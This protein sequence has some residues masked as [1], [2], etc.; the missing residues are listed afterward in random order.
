MHTGR[1]GHG[2]RHHGHHGRPHGP[3]YGYYGWGGWPPGYGYP[4]AA[5]PY[6]YVG[7]PWWLDDGVISANAG[8]AMRHG[9]ELSNNPHAGA[10]GLR[11]QAQTRTLSGRTNLTTLDGEPL[12]SISGQLDSSNPF[13]F[14][15]DGRRLVPPYVPVGLDSRYRDITQALLGGVVVHLDRAGRVR[16]ANNILARG[17]CIYAANGAAYPLSK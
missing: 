4:W 12:F 14:T 8:G 17:A 6:E 3:P 10:L 11:A 16:L 1:H 15:D 5:Y 13:L 2:H 7:E 9:H